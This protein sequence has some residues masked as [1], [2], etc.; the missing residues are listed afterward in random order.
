M[1]KEVQ[2]LQARLQYRFSD[3]ALL[4]QALTHAS[5]SNARQ[6][7]NERLEF[8]GDAIVGLV[9]S[10]HLYLRFPEASEGQ[11]TRIKSA[12]VSRRTLARVGRSLGLPQCLRVDSGLKQR[13]R[14]PVSLAANAYEAVVGA[15]L[16][17]R[18]IA[19]ASEFIVRTLGPEIALVVSGRHEWDYKTILQLKAQAQG[20][21]P[22]QYE[23]ARRT[24]PDHRGRFMTV[25]CIDGEE[26]GSGWGT[27]KKGSEQ[28]AASRA[29]EKCYP[30]WMN[31]LQ[32][33]PPEQ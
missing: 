9:V 12:V 25:V 29:L 13:K 7:S 21:P 33:L 15:M 1:D 2:E 32:T 30:D 3:L 19:A 16:L 5:A 14:Y 10:E 26:C 18:G 23:V 31:G 20:K 24:G 4:S 17:D 6:P 27:T 11:M 28:S 8:L 22:P